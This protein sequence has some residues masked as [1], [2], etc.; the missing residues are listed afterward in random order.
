MYVNQTY[1]D[2]FA[3]Y[4]NIT[5][6][7]CISETNI[8]LSI[9]LK[10]TVCVFVYRCI[11]L[12]R[13]IYDLS[14]KRQ[15]QKFCFYRQNIDDYIYMHGKKHIYIHGNRYF[16]MVGLKVIFSFLSLICTL[17]NF[18]NESLYFIIK[19]KK[20]FKKLFHSNF[21]YHLIVNG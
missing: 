4:A 8:M 14:E 15:L 12:H 17:Q 5:S 19:I 16:W 7:H 9:Y 21:K 2:L 18:Y 6:F 13:D 10:Y 1:C 20:F 11:Y 3:I